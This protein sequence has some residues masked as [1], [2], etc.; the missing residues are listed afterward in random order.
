MKK[1]KAALRAECLSRRRSL[2]ED[3]RAAAAERAAQILAGQPLKAMGKIVSGYWPLH[4]EFDV[5]PALLALGK[6][7][8]ALALPV[9]ETAKAP[10]I[11]RRYAPGDTL[12][13][14]TTHD[15]YE[16]LP[17]AQ[18]L[19]PDILL[20]PLVAFDRNGFRLGLGG[21]YY[22]RTL[23]GLGKRITI[24]IGYADAEVETVPSE[25]HDVKMD[26]ILTEKEWIKIA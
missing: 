22:D 17:S 10:L 11:F 12:L 26:Y 13:K 21:G 7:G 15:I 20:V 8:F 9:I 2:P 25:A 18:I 3:A 19:V 1:T 16:P 23:A 14:D 6:A 4:G 5:R 24:G